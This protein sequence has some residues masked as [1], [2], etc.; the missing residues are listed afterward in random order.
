[1]DNTKGK[2]DAATG[3][4]D[5]RKTNPVISVILSGDP[6]SN[7]SMEQEYLKYCSKLGITARETGSHGATRKYWGE[8]ITI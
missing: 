6:L 5:G 7:N 3:I 1:M 8:K 4:K 2:H